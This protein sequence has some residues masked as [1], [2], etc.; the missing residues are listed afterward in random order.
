MLGA[1]CKNFTKENAYKPA[2]QHHTREGRDTH[3]GLNSAGIQQQLLKTSSQQLTGG[4]VKG[5]RGTW[6]LK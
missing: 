5:R 4:L 2:V 1:N 3:L 6:V